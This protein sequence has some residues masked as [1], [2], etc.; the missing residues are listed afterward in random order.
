MAP[1]IWR[2]LRL[3]YWKLFLL[4]NLIFSSV[5]LLLKAHEIARFAAIGGSLIDILAFSALQLAHLIPLSVPI[6]SWIAAF[7][8]ATGLCQSA[9]LTSLRA[10]G[11]SISTI[12]EPIKSVAYALSLIS[13][14]II[15]L[16]T[17]ASKDLAAFFL[18]K[19]ARSHPLSTLTVKKPFMH[20]NYF[21]T[22][23]L[24]N[25]GEINHLLIAYKGLQNRLHLIFAD[26]VTEIKGRLYA[27]QITTLGTRKN[28]NQTVFYAQS[29]SKA[30]QPIETELLT[31]FF[32]PQEHLPVQR[33][34]LVTL[35]NG[36]FDDDPSPT[37]KNRHLFELERRLYLCLA[38]YLLTLSAISFGIG[39]GRS[40]RKAPL[41]TTLGF[42]AL[43][44]FIYLTA[45]GLRHHPV[46]A[47]LY[48]LSGVFLMIFSAQSRIKKIEQG[49]A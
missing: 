31:Y 9:E 22:Y 13:F 45:K 41:M 27:D 49:I 11:L 48:F 20:Q 34:S 42:V 16:I 8:L 5:I 1:L 2:S 14:V 21:M 6:A 29:A 40:Q 26:A 33:M 39:I 19:A 15:F 7:A 17:P 24:K 38:P 47:A 32:N 25:S 35:L 36:I 18:V 23:D 30:K 37:N 12:F 28:G 44:F 10:C 43:Y 4:A 46:I 3:T